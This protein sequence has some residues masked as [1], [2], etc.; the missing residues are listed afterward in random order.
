M[1][2]LTSKNFLDFSINDGCFS[3]DIEEN[4]SSEDT[5]DVMS[6]DKIEKIFNY[7]LNK[8]DDIDIH[9]LYF[10]SNKK[11]TKN[12]E[13]QKSKLFIITESTKLITQMLKKK[14]GKQSILNS[15]KTHDKNCEDNCLRK[16]QTHSLSS[17]PHFTNS[18]IKGFGKNEEF[19]QLS[20]EF[21]KKIK[22]DYFCELKNKTLGEILCNKISPKY[23]Q[24]E[25]E[26]KKTYERIKDH[27]ILKK[28]FEMDFITYFKKYYMKSIKCINLKEFG[29][30]K[31]II[32]SNKCKMYNDLIESIQKS[33]NEDNGIYIKNIRKCID[34]KYFS[35]KLF[36]TNK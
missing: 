14:R 23:K 1:S 11:D 35:K 19:Y 24:D 8:E 12:S 15:N 5:S 17:V 18:I 31:E 32:L 33:N 3:F 36:K 21:K 13:K 22:N 4:P 30:E 25:Y 34:K 26:N 27:Q 9:D 10:K 7:K 29:L 2:E 28:I 6:Y 20:Y 16:T